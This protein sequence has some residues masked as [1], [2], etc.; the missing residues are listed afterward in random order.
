MRPRLSTRVREHSGLVDLTSDMGMAAEDQTV[1]PDKG[2]HMHMVSQPRVAVG[3]LVQYSPRTF[4]TLAT[5]MCVH[6]MPLCRTHRPAR[7]AYCC[8]GV[9]CGWQCQGGVTCGW[10][11]RGIAIC[12]GPLQGVGISTSSGIAISAAAKEVQKEASEYHTWRCA[13][14]HW[15]YATP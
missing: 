6:E 3:Q 1:V 13:R 8:G 11:C 10:Q 14:H 12:T 5:P 7:R 2:R 9:T 15:W 4:C